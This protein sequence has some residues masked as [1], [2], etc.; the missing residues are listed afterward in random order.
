MKD[1]AQARE[2]AKTMVELG[3]DAGV[4]T[5]ALLTDMSTQ[6]GLTAGNAIE[7]EESVE[8]LA[9]GGPQDVI[10]LT[11]RLAEEMLS[12][13]GLHGADP[14]AALKDGRAMDV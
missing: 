10:E 6:L 1:L 7:V 12:A 9:G 3:T 5:V 2:L 8:V 4:K 11:V 13:A 14:A